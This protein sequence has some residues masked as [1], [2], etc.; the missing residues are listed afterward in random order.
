MARRLDPAGVA[1]RAAGLARPHQ[2][3]RGW[4]TYRG[5]LR[6]PGLQ[7]GS[8]FQDPRRD[9]GV[10]K[11]ASARPESTPGHHA[12]W[13]WRAAAAG[14]A[15]DRLPGGCV[16]DWGLCRWVSVT[17]TPGARKSWDRFA[18]PK[19]WSRGRCVTGGPVFIPAGADRDQLEVQ[20][21]RVQDAMNEVS[22]LAEK[23]A[24]T[25]E[26]PENRNQ[27]L[28]ARNE[29]GQRRQAA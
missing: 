24:E 21:L 7:H 13:P 19:P 1:L 14:A 18:V 10:A 9:H 5:D 27:E 15:G 4:R 26:W 25:G 2:P 12:R 8:R 28:G 29:D 6:T 3:A 20:R 22:S 17:I 23:W 16:P 11:H